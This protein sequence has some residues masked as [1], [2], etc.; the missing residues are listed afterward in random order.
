MLRFSVELFCL[1][2]PKN[3]VG[4]TLVFQ[5]NFGIEKVLWT[6]GGW[7]IT[8]FRR[9]FLRPT[10]SKIFL[11]GPLYFRKVMVSI[12]FWIIGVSR[13]CLFLSHTAENF[14]RGAF[15]SFTK[16]C[17]KILWTK[18]GE[19]ESHFSVKNFWS[20]FRKISYGNPLVCHYFRVSKKFYP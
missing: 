19:G 5:K 16:W 7:G 15:L 11:G 14:R 10:V 3:F 9:E 17:P 8:F 12:F 6:G 1:T 2:G 20:N 18:G 13:F 4:G